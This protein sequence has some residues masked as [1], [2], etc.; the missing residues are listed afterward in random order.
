MSPD[1]KTYL[2]T[3]VLSEQK[4]ISYRQVSRHFK[5]H[6]NAAKCMLYEFYTKEN[7][8]KPTSVYATYLLAGTKK[9]TLELNPIDAASKDANGHDIPPSSP[10]G[11]Q[12]S[13][14][15]VSQATERDDQ[16][17]A[18]VKT[19]HIT[20]VRE[21]L[22]EQTKQQYDKITSIHI[23]SLS[24]ARIQDM[25]ILTDVSR[26][27]FTE[28][29]SKLDPLIHNKE[30]GVVQNPH[31]RRRKGKRPTGIDLSVTAPA[32]KMQ[33]VK[34]E[35]KQGLKPA[36]A[37]RKEE[38]KVNGE[39]IGS[40]PSSRDSTPAISEAKKVP[41]LKHE[42]SSLFKAFA[43][44][45]EKP[46]L[47]KQNTTASSAS[48]ETD[49][50]VEEESLGESED[51]AVF[52]DTNTKKPAS[53]KRAA[54]E[55]QREKEEKRKK[56]RRMMDDDAEEENEV[57]SVDKATNNTAEP[58]TAQASTGDD[59][60]APVGNEHKERDKDTVA[61]S[62]SDDNDDE[63]EGKASKKTNSQTTDAL[64]Q[65]TTAV[66]PPKRKRG[67]R[68]IMKKRTMKDEDGYLV[69]REEEAW[70]SFSEDEEPASSVSIARPA[71]APGGKKGK[72]GSAPS[73]QQKAGPG[74]SGG[75]ATAA[76][77]GGKKD[78]MSFF[79]KR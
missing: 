14:P 16:L 17:Q 70:E 31:V 21:E 72:S 6:V 49:S 45:K 58:V 20:L 56:L 40:K 15:N 26:S 32:A 51:E 13:M 67:R 34:S 7:K 73:S 23:Y 71:F 8:K 9:A 10:P 25:Q 41:G 39:D 38:A 53:K 60:T 37:L 52:L 30:Y 61:W 1:F 35:V 47:K 46:T 22:L 75:A 18:R 27:I 11:L 33:A 64:S 4:T 59:E 28:Y 78:I 66:A 74:K 2:A 68:K 43:K 79:G 55:I 36:S 48:K 42:S 69:T 62:D 76:K 3:E 77:T 50:R 12:S 65:D 29:H 19:K 54:T 63:N 24:P 44:Q 5:I 57:P